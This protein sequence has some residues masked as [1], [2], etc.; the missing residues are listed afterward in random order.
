MRGLFVESKLEISWVW[1]ANEFR[2]S[3]HRHFFKLLWAG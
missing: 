3:P 1:H 2:S